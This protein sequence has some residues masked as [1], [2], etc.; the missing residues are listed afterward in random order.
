MAQSSQSSSAGKLMLPHLP[1]WPIATWVPSDGQDKEPPY[2]P[3]V[4]FTIQIPFPLGFIDNS[5]IVVQP[6]GSWAD[7]RAASVFGDKAFVSMRIGN[8]P[9]P[10]RSRTH[11]EVLTS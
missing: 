6:F 7:S 8:I 5:V 9:I 10:A 3:I 11:N 1:K 2:G 4:T